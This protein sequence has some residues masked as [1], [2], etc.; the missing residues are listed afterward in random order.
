MLLTF[1]FIRCIWAHFRFWIKGQN[2]GRKKAPGFSNQWFQSRQWWLKKKKDMSKHKNYS[3]R[4]SLGISKV[5]VWYRFV[6]VKLCNRKEK[7]MKNTII[8][9]GGERAYLAAQSISTCCGTVNE[10]DTQTRAS[11]FM[12]VKQLRGF[13]W[14]SGLEVM[15]AG[16]LTQENEGININTP[17]SSPCS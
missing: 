3:Q 11:L 15:G 5:I 13:R 10:Q 8:I 17:E 16:W 14:Q 7:E 12:A 1:L 6:C 4:H 2:D 9:G